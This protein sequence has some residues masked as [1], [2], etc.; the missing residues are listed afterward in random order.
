MNMLRKHV[1][2]SG[3]LSI[4]LVSCLEL[5]KEV[6][7]TNPITQL[8][9]GLVKSDAVISHPFGASCSFMFYNQEIADTQTLLCS[10]LYLVDMDENLLRSACEEAGA[11]LSIKNPEISTVFR[12]DFCESSRR[13]SSGFCFG[14][15]PSESE[16]IYYYSPF[17]TNEE[18]KSN[19]LIPEL[20]NAG[21]NWHTGNIIKTKNSANGVKTHSSVDYVEVLEK[22]KS[23]LKNVIESNKKFKD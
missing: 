13:I 14:S 12:G 7:T 4:F 20:S 6:T 8:K 1:F 15:Q 10:E 23:K 9:G 5:K 21:Y 16:V 19:C 11:E 18:A 17:F 22:Y 3:I 2:V